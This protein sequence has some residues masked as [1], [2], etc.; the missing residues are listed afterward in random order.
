M[1][2]LSLT[3]SAGNGIRISGLQPL[4]VSAL[5]LYPED[6]DPGL[7]KKRQ[8]ISDLTFRKEVVVCVDLAQRGLGGDNSWGATPHEQWRLYPTGRTYKY[9]FVLSPVVA[10]K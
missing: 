6:L 1:R 2:W 5:H 8:H 4:S 10:G 9:G 7:T 3:D